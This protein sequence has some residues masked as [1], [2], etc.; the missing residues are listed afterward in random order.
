MAASSIVSS[1]LAALS[2]DSLLYGVYFVLFCISTFL[3]VRRQHRYVNSLPVMR[4]P[5]FV[6]G[7][8]LF[9]V[10]TAHWIIVVYRSFPAFLYF[11]GGTDPLAYYTDLGR[12][13]YVVATALAVIQPVIADL[14]LIYRLWII[15]SRN[16]Y[17]IV[18]PLL[19]IS[20]V[21]GCGI[22]AVYELVIFRV[23]DSIFE[24][25]LSN[26]I[27]AC[28]AMS[29]G[30]NIYC[31]TFIVA[32][33]WHVHRMTRDLGAGVDLMSILVVFIESAGLYVF[34]TVFYLIVYATGSVLE[35]VIG[36]LL[37]PVAGIAFTLINVRI[38]M[39]YATQ[40]DSSSR[41]LSEWKIA[42][43]QRR[44]PRERRSLEPISLNMLGT[45]DTSA[46]EEEDKDGIV[47]APGS[48]DPE[49]AV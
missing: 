14:V 47:F 41:T 11:D 19:V 20:A 28:C 13:S 10:V 40:T 29:A 39:G 3:M 46:A 38:G 32:K 37:L 42:S 5:A 25:I 1:N 8:F 12:K 35:P 34:W 24:A 16:P 22:G 2:M 4:N 30:N 49:R 48:S 21:L 17:I 6:G 31:C 23:G 33:L 26:L 7:M 45:N 44:R 27:T 36:I 43:P 9:M 18:L 15:W